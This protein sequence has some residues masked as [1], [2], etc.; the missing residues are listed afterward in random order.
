M[1]S[2]HL[3]LARLT[4]SKL[5]TRN[6]RRVNRHTPKKAVMVI[7]WHAGFGAVTVDKQAT[8]ARQAMGTP[9]NG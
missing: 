7:D 8:I 6:V 3:E 5:L 4:V 2:P 1:S 9:A